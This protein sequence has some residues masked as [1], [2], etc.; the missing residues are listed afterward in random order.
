[1][2][3]GVEV[4]LNRVAFTEGGD[5]LT[6][7]GGSLAVVT[8]PERQD[9]SSGEGSQMASVRW[10]VPVPD[11]VGGLE[12]EPIEQWLAVRRMERLLEGFGMMRGR[13]R[14]LVIQNCMTRAIGR[15]RDQHGAD[16]SALAREE[17]EDALGR[18]FSFVLGAESLGDQNPVLVGRAALEASD[19]ARLWPGVVLTYDRLP[20]DF[21]EAMRASKVMPTPP[22]LPGNMLEQ[23]L[24]S[25]SLK[26]LLTRLV[27]RLT[28]GLPGPAAPI[29]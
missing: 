2:G 25:W 6:E 19:A 15:W 1:M 8:L 18:W 23:S 7:G 27:G 5:D 10:T 26:E 9:S 16:L 24:E 4:S 14:E 3:R 11:V 17:V 29:A 13:H 28:R 22:E 12:P 20:P 21:V